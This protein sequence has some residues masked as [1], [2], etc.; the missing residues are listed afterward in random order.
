VLE[1]PSSLL[2]TLSGIDGSG[3]TS[4]AQALFDAFAASGVHAI[5]MT[6]RIGRLTP[7][8][9]LIAWVQ[10]RRSG[11]GAPPSSPRDTAERHW[12]GWKLTLWAIATVV[13]YA[14]WLQYVRWKLWRGNIVVADR[15]L[16]DFAVEFTILVKSQRRLA[17]VLLSVLPLVAPRPEQSYFLR[18]DAEISRHRKP[19]DKHGYDH[20]E[21]CAAY[22]RLMSKY[23]VKVV[24]NTASFDAVSGA[25]VGEVMA[26][27]ASRRG[28][29]ATR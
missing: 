23:A 21:V 5:G 6:S 27:Y 13:D 9:L 18:V 28:A 17:D 24:D 3:K 10:H 4:H 25:I 12:K 20:D 1:K 15:Y 16:L 19:E 8:R 7:L 11:G 14:L 22:D 26:T 2:V 29:H